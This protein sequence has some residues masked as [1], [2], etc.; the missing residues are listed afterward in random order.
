M[1]DIHT[2]FSRKTI[3]LNMNECERRSFLRFFFS[4]QCS[5]GLDPSNIGLWS[6]TISINLPWNNQKA[7][8]SK[9]RSSTQYLRVVETEKCYKL[10]KTGSS[11]DKEMTKNDREHSWFFTD[12]FENS[13]CS[14]NCILNHQNGKTNRWCQNPCG[15]PHLLCRGV[16]PAQQDDRRQTK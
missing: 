2:S 6:G 8:E 10:I 3:R 12:S 11:R 9:W 5:K 1:G 4:L 16:N 15:N 14:F 7:G 13:L